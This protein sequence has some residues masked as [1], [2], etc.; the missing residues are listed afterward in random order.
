[1][2][3]NSKDEAWKN[4]YIQK[5]VYLIEEYELVKIG[6]HPNFTSVG[7]FYKAHGTCPQTLLK[8]YRRYR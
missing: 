5:Y 4:N 7:V 8:Y 2:G 1:M 3:I 6:D